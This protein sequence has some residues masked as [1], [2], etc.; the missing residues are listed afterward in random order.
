[1]AAKEGG[2]L[3]WLDFLPV[4]A[5]AIAEEASARALPGVS[6]ELTASIYVVMGWHESRFNPR[7]SHDQGAGY[8]LFGTHEATLGRPVPEDV[9]GQVTAAHDLLAQSFAIC[10]ARPVSERLGWYAAGGD[11]C[12]RRLGLSRARVWEAERLLRTYP[13][14]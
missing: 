13:A 5:E 12:E 14:R 1:M 9:V 7:A 8:G 10:R 11:G 2:T 6:R 4:E 3:P